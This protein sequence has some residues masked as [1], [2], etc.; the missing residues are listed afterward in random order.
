MSSH[1]TAAGTKCKQIHTQANPEVGNSR[2]RNHSE[3]N[4]PR[5]T[6]CATLETGYTGYLAASPLNSGSTGLL[7]V[8]VRK[9]SS[10]HCFPSAIKAVI[11]RFI[12]RAPM[13]KDL[14]LV[15]ERGS[16]VQGATVPGK[17][18]WV[19]WPWVQVLLTQQCPLEPALAL[20]QQV[21]EQVGW[22]K[23]LE[24]GS[25]KGIRINSSLG[26]SHCTWAVICCAGIKAAVS[27]EVC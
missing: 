7:M 27:R 24:R 4:W 8:T 25:D 20:G 3:A 1:H 15:E 11:R 5:C 21:G 12:V 9:N 16:R 26:V 6:F 23:R 19:T 18:T 22:W 10:S 14:E 2:G 13:H 17:Q